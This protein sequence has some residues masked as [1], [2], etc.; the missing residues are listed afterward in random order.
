MTVLD[1][2]LHQVVEVPQT[3]VQEVVRHALLSGTK[4]VGHPIFRPIWDGIAKEFG[5]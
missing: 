3:V 4:A 5:R 2:F 1:F